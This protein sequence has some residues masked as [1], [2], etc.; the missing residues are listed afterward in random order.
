L[1]PL[2]RNV[3]GRLVV[4]VL[5]RDEDVGGAQGL[6]QRQ[7]LHGGAQLGEVALAGEDRDVPRLGVGDGHGGRRRCSG[8][9][10][11]EGG[12]GRGGERADVVGWWRDVDLRMSMLWGG[13]GAYGAFGA[14]LTHDKR[15]GKI[16]RSA[17]RHSCKGVG[18]DSML[19][20]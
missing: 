5:A 12:V 19:L 8:R 7:G 4:V 16:D 1:P 11:W 2:G 3:R 18:Y 9:S 13:V 6:A 17:P 10:F 20:E 15:H 14:T